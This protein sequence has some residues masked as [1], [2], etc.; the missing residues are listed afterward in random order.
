MVKETPWL[1]DHQANINALQ[2]SPKAL[3]ELQQAASDPKPGYHIHH[4]VEQ[5]PAR[6]SDFPESMINGPENKVRIPRY[7]HEDINGWYS[8]PNEEFIWLSPRDYLR[9]KDWDE[10][11]RIG[12]KALRKFE[13][14]KP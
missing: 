3:E 11:T 12:L 14:L 9:D 7:K 2:E 8:R 13:V 1:D 10:R 5:T 4:I 6:D